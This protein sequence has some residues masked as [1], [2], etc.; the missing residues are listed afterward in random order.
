MLANISISGL[1]NA[2]LNLP[3]MKQYKMD[4]DAFMV[5]MNDLIGKDLT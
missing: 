1:V 3:K 4:K 5:V 2:R